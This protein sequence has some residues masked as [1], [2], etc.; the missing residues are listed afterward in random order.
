MH[1]MPSSAPAPP[2]SSSAS[3]ASTRPASVAPRPRSPFK[4]PFRLKRCRCQAVRPP[5][6]LNDAFARL[7]IPVRPVWLT[8]HVVLD[9]SPAGFLLGAHVSLDI[10]L[11]IDLFTGFS[12]VMP[13]FLYPFIPDSS[14]LS[15][16]LP[17]RLLCHRTS[18][19]TAPFDLVPR[20]YINSLLSFRIPDSFRIRCRAV[21]RQQD[22]PF[23][24]FALFSPTFPLSA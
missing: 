6:L 23:R 21:C 15:L 3:F 5:S 14:L 7:S 13:F 10:Y 24:L 4:S 22:T 18:T 2:T 11:F 16:R 20:Y 19:T 17:P 9:P 8:M 12:Y 1:V